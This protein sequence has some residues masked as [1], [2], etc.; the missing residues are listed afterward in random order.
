[1][2]YTHLTQDERYQIH[3]LKRQNIS[4]ARIGAELQRD[5]STISRELK[6]NAEPHGYKPAVAHKQ[7]RARQCERRNA[8]CFSAEQWRHVQAY[9]RLY[10]SPQQCSGRLKLEKAI[11]ISPESIYQHAYRDKAKGGDLVSYLRC[12]KV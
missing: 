12:Q 3:A 9:L 1:M 5:R 4:L 2:T 11:T 7:A 6:R 8:V 10:L